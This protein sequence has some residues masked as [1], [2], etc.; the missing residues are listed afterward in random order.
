MSSVTCHT[1][2]LHLQRPALTPYKLTGSSVAANVLIV[3]PL[4]L[5]RR[6]A[7]QPT[8]P[9]HRSRQEVRAHR[10]A[11]L[12]PRRV[13]LEGLLCWTVMLVADSTVRSRMDDGR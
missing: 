11:R 2:T 9:R 6:A 13:R 4:L 8:P 5:A 3:H 7:G 12:V 1:K 10:K